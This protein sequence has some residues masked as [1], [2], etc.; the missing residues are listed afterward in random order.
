[1]LRYELHYTAIY[2]YY[3]AALPAMLDSSLCPFVM[4]AARLAGWLLA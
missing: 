3:V 2:R 4:H 1:M